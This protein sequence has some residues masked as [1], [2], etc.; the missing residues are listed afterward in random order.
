MS[1][2]LGQGGRTVTLVGDVGLVRD[3]EGLGPTVDVPTA[4]RLL[5]CG[6]TLGY[7]LVRRG[8]FPCQ[9]LRLGHRLV[10]PTAELLR[11]LGVEPSP[12]GGATGAAG[13]SVR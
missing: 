4:A 1:C 11:V 7:E 6:R 3:L 9:V 5:G 2:G 12:A 13:S 10:V 8:E